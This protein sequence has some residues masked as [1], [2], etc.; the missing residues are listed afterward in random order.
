MADSIIERTKELFNDEEFRAIT[1]QIIGYEEMQ[2]RTVSDEVRFIWN[3]AYGEARYE[4]NPEMQRNEQ[5]IEMEY[6][7]GLF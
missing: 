2:G 6:I 3:S 1:K 7:D 5:Q 4:R